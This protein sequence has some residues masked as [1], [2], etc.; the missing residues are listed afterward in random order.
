MLMLL[1]LLVFAPLFYGIG[2]SVKSICSKKG[3]INP[4]YTYFEIFSA[5]KL[6]SDNTSL[7]QSIASSVVLSSTIIASFVMFNV[8]ASC[9]FIIF[10]C[11][12]L[13]AKLFE[14]LINASCIKN[15]YYIIPVFV[16]SMASVFAL[17]TTVSFEVLSMI[18]F[19]HPLLAVLLV[20]V[21]LLFMVM[22]EN[23]NEFK[24]IDKAFVLYADMLRTSMYAGFIGLILFS[25]NIWGFF[26]IL[27]VS[28]VISGIIKLLRNDFS[29]VLKCTLILVSICL[30]LL[31][32]IY[33]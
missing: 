19:T 3:Y 10:A 4:F 28:F 32:L 8:A 15:E 33:K 11:F 25:E 20:I 22:D 26:G 9:D 31:V 14:L 7:Y 13:L 30:P 1:S 18:K 16:V 27:L 6:F 29:N 21:M 23:C 24:G 12:I 17:T 2:T 5:M